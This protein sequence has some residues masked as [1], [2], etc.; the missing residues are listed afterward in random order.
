MTQEPENLNISSSCE[1]AESVNGSCRKKAYFFSD[2]HLGASYAGESI[3]RER[4]AVRFLEEIAADAAEIYLL[5]DIIDYWF[6][7]RYV[8]PRGYVRFFG[9]LADLSDRGIK[10]TWLIGNHDIWIFD[11]IPTELG[12]EVIDGVLDR[13]VLGRTRMVLAHGDHVWGRSLGFG[14]IRA[15]FRNRFCQRLYAAVH[16][17]WTVPL[18]YKWSNSSRK[19]GY[20][21]DSS[22]DASTRAKLDE[23]RGVTE[24]VR[25]LEDYCNGYD[26]SLPPGE[27]KPE[28]Y[29]FGHLHKVVER[30]LKCG[31]EMI[32]E[33][34]WLT[35]FSYAVYDGNS[36]KMAYYCE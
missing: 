15:I 6:E 30:R 35:H 21:A 11:Y 34:D 31:A 5:G 9:K 16:P 28:Y 29:L 12:V 36:M 1:P 14:M 26:A 2:L 22:L 25:L 17:R 7:Y 3:E 18:A 33:G 23:E 13:M 32:I 10:I 24:S 19:A 8:V 4:K 27:I 20:L